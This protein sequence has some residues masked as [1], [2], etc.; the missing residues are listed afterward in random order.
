MLN[1]EKREAV[2]AIIEHIREMEPALLGTSIL[3]EKNEKSSKELEEAYVSIKAR[4]SWAEY[5]SAEREFEL[6][7]LVERSGMNINPSMSEEEIET[8]FKEWTKDSE[9]SY[10][11]EIQYLYDSSYED[12]EGLVKGYTDTE[13]VVEKKILN[14]VEID[15]CEYLFVPF[16]KYL[17]SSLL[18]S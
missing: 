5:R 16:I 9:R 18:C 4:S 3:I 15:D 8:M 7:E 10:D 14:L 2:L 17:Q 13:V 6:D 11:N 1:T 12:C